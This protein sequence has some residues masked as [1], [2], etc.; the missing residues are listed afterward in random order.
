MRRILIFFISLLL[1]QCEESPT[2][3]I[4]FSD[5]SKVPIIKASLNNKPCY[6]MVDTGASIS[7]LDI[8]QTKSYNFKVFNVANEVLGIGGKSKYFGLSNVNVQLDSIN[9][10]DSFHGGDLSFLVKTIE[11]N[12]GFKIVGII[13]SDVFKAQGFKIDYYTNS[14]KYQ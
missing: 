7:I 11:L 5:I 4:H 1:Y 9:L 14:I 8:T 12:S 3:E 13:G 10:S 6:L 2:K